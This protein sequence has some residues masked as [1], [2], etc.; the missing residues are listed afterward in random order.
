[1]PRLVLAKYYLGATTFFMVRFRR[2]VPVALW[3]VLLDED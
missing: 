2:F 3:G 1:M